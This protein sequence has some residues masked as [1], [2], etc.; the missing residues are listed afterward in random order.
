MT[1]PP[2]EL[3]DLLFE[4]FGTP[5]TL[6]DIGNRLVAFSVQPTRDIDAVRQRTIL[7]KELDE[8]SRYVHS[9]AADATTFTR[10][11]AA[12]HLDVLERVVIPLRVDGFTTGRLF[13]I[14]P[15]H[16]VRPELLAEFEPLFVATGRQLEIERMA[17]NNP[18]SL[19]SSLTSSNPRE[20]QLAADAFAD[21]GV[22]DESAT[23]RIVAIAGHDPSQRPT[24]PT[25]ARTFGG[26]VWWAD[27]ANRLVVLTPGDQNHVVD[28]V[29]E[30]L[31]LMDGD[32]SPLTPCA[33]IGPSVTSLTDVHQSY[34]LALR[35]LQLA[36]S[37]LTGSRLSDW[38]SLPGWRPLLL[39]RSEQVHS[40]LDRR[41]R[42]M[43]ENEERSVLGA[44][45]SYL[46]RETDIATLAEELHLH[47]ATLY[48]RNKR[49]QERYGLAWDDPEDRFATILGLRLGLLHDLSEQ[50][51]SVRAH[52]PVSDDTLSKPL[53]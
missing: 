25:L 4:R 21:F 47:R 27:M 11:P 26:H 39:L 18:Q 5:I 30:V 12:P 16:V 48:S 28:C 50:A 1:Y 51:R 13:L 29:E 35:T 49:L 8:A 42:A 34:Q 43:I 22:L 3:V 46:E 33:G 6:V 10:I 19:L 9:A 31:G 32:G 23:L 7:S 52:E 15:G 2:Q 44:A 41:V 20:R 36:E 37:G 38:E 45:R 24:D 53:S 14:D 40:V 17:K